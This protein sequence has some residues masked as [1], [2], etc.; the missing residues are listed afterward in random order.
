MSYIDKENSDKQLSID[1]MFINALKEINRRMVNKSLNLKTLN[2]IIRYVMEA[3]EKTP[4]KGKDQKDFAM[5]L[6]KNLIDNTCY[7]INEKKILL[8]LYE[9]DTISETIEMIVSASKGEMNINKV[10]TV[11]S[12]ILKCLSSC[13]ND[14]DE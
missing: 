7:S 1:K 13:S 8:N 5:R 10:K 6:I 2:V 3:V 9:N 4:L 12:C 11:C 14:D